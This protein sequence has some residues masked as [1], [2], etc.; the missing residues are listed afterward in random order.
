MLNHLLSLNVFLPLIGVFFLLLIK[1]KNTKIIK[2]ISSSITGI[3]LWI[4]FQILAGFNR[5]KSGLQYVEHS[6]WTE[7]LSIDFFLGVD[8][9]N[10]IF[11]ALTSIVF[12]ISILTFWKKNK[13]VKEYLIIF[14]LLD[15]GLMGLF[16]SFDLFMFLLFLGLTLFSL[17]FL[18]IVHNDKTKDKFHRLGFVIIIAYSFILLGVL[19]LIFGNES[20]SYNMLEIS[21]ASSYSH[22]FEIITFLLLFIGFALLFPIFPFHSW[23]ISSITKL[24]VYINIIILG[25]IIKIGAYGLMRLGFYLLPYATIKLSPL[26]GIIGTVNIIY[27]ALCAITQKDL[28]NMIGYYSIM[29]IGFVL[30]GMATIKGGAVNNFQAAITGIS[31]AWFHIFNHGTIVI[32]LLLLSDIFPLNKIKDI[33]I[34]ENKKWASSIFPGIVILT[35]FAGFGLPGFSTFISSLFCLV[36]AIQLSGINI[37]AMISVIGIALNI[38]CFF[39][40]FNILFSNF[41]GNFDSIFSET[42]KH[43]IFILLP[44]I[45]IILI[46]GIFPDIF[47]SLI[48]ISVENLV[49]LITM[50]SVK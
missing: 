48:N 28:K 24:P 39:K 38:F 15:T 25:I 27:G 40:W 5:Q 47:L 31:G 30:L 18:I 44:V 7:S 35:L 4:I 22:G 34:S 42:K 32:I 13:S 11:I 37:F 46:L 43:Y 2:T 20:F 41:S 21:H 33:K 16:L 45:F 50:F 9:I 8:G 14:L 17:Y 29:Q 10:I 3:Q 1:N 36:G 23:L 12:F 26:L 49:K 19:L 6:K